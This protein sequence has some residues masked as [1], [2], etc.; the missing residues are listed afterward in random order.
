MFKTLPCTKHNNYTVQNNTET[1]NVNYSL[2]MKSRGCLEQPLTP[3][4][5]FVL[6]LVQHCLLPLLLLT[7]YLGLEAL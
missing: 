2:S 7:Q 1:K 3:S 4:V 6:T 5:Q